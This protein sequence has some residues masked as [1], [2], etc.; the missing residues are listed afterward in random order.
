MSFVRL[1]AD[2]LRIRC[3]D[4]L[5]ILSYLLCMTDAI[6]ISYTTLNGSAA[7]RVASLCL[8]AAALLVM[9][10]KLIWDGKQRMSAL[11]FTGTVFLF[12]PF[13]RSARGTT[14]CFT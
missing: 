14:I 9:G 10:G 4:G 5:Y 6:L 3:S 11:L 12:P 1:N 7:A 8:R 2:R 13:P